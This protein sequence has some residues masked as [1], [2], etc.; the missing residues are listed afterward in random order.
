MLKNAGPL[1]SLRGLVAG[2]IAKCKWCG[3]YSRAP[4]QCPA[5]VEIDRLRRLIDTAPVALMDT[6]AELG[7]CAQTEAGFK[8]LY[9]LQGHLVA[10]LDL[11]LPL[12]VKQHA[13]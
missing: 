4:C 6:R 10:L 12:P 9:A 8:P 2:T 7:L 1:S 11:G 5:E 13:D 3:S